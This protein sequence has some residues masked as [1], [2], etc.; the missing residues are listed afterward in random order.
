MSAETLSKIYRLVNLSIFMKLCENK[1]TLFVTIIVVGVLFI[2]PFNQVSGSV[3]PVAEKSVQ[4]SISLQSP[5]NWIFSNSSMHNDIKAL[6]ST[7]KVLGKRIVPAVL[8]REVVLDASTLYQYSEFQ[9]YLNKLGNGNLQWGVAYNFTSDNF[10]LYAE[11]ISQSNTSQTYY[12]FGV[13]SN[14]L[15]ITGPS[16]SSQTVSHASAYYISPNWAGYEL[17]FHPQ[18][19]YYNSAML[20]VSNILSPPSNQMS[21]DFMSVYVWIGLT[22]YQ[23]GN[24]P[25]GTQ[26][27][28]QTG[29]S[30]AYYKAWDQFWTG[31]YWH[32]YHI[33]YE[34]LSPNHPNSP[35]YNYPGS[36]DLS[37]GWQIQFSVFNDAP[38]FTYSAYI[39]NTSQNF[40][41]TSDHGNFPT[42]YIQYVTEAANLSNGISS[43]I[44]Q[45]AE[46]YPSVQFQNPQIEVQGIPGEV[47]IAGLYQDGYYHEYYLEQTPNNG[48]NIENNFGPQMSWLNS[49][50]DYSYVNG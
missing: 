35:S 42:Y 26:T 33:W 50:F 6:N 19:I 46:F 20:G 36:P 5:L 41:V 13:D 45:I 34:T 8:F 3:T 48:V 22:E 21:G 37:P 10:T 47:G 18:E 38:D 44:G 31:P 39:T 12:T 2:L 11:F 23:G 4:P 43:Y 7:A 49:Y 9:Y 15:R 27:L 1:I 28:A 14:S 32:N 16:M 40:V 25:S 29:Y 17:Y 24:S 30:R